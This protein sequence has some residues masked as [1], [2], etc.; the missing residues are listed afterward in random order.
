MAFSIAQASPQG[1]SRGASALQDGWR[2]IARTRSVA[3]ARQ[4][5]EARLGLFVAAA[6]ELASETGSAAFTVSQVVERAG[7]SL[8]SFYADFD[9]KDDLLLALIGHDSGVGAAM[10]RELVDR[11]RAPARRLR[12]YVEGFFSFLAAAGELGVDPYVSVLT[13]EHRRLRESRPEGTSVALAPFLDLL[14]TELRAAMD[15]GAIRRGDAVRDARTVFDLLLGNVHEFAVGRDPLPPAEL[16]AYVW[17]F[18]WK[19]FA[20]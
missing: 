20:S 7:L 18:C 11:H 5:S 10:L 2:E 3:A 8:K 16:A 14:E 15:A 4:R 12:A 9:G 17:S 1:A 19:G 6:R 13:S